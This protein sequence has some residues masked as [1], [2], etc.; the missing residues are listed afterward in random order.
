MLTTL[1]IHKGKKVN[2]TKSTEYLDKQSTKK[3]I[4]SNRPGGDSQQQKFK[5]NGVQTNESHPT[6]L[7]V[8][9]NKTDKGII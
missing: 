8:I 1:S 6:G 5:I 9:L 7:E 2:T 3:R 4:P